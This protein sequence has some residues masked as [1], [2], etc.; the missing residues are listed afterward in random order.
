MFSTV[1]KPFGLALLFVFAFGFKATAQFEDVSIFNLVSSSTSASWFGC[2]LSM[3][4]FNG[5]GW[6]DVTAA[7]SNGNV[8]LYLGGPDGLT[9]HMELE[10]DNEAKAVLWV[11]IE[12]DGDL[13]LFVGVMNIGMFLYVQQEDGSLP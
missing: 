10:H 8:S 3:A 11:D 5:D 7:G 4:D 12:N 2:G 9:E 13:D 6:D 1:H